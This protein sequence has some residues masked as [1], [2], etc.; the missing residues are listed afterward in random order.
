[1]PS[2]PEEIEE[3]IWGGS[4][5]DEFDDRLKHTGEG[6]LSMANAGPDT[7][8]Q[9]FFLTFTSCPHLDRKHSVFGTVVEGIDVLKK[10][11]SIAVDR[12]ER[13]REEIKIITID[14]LTDPAIEARELEQKRLEKVIDMR[15]RNK[16]LQKSQKSKSDL[17]KQNDRADESVSVRRL[18]PPPKNTKFGNFSGW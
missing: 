12:K 4:F 3:C 14:V 8:K 1:M 7:N 9:Q 10:L 15:R 11:E 16:E 17:I 18:P 13:P 2:N 6:V 5:P